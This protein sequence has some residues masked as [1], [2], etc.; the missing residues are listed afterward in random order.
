[1]DE[2]VLVGRYGASTKV[3]GPFPSADAAREGCNA[4]G[5]SEVEWQ[6]VALV[7]PSGI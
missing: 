1:M 3:V 4:L 2:W 6:V 5:L 7:R